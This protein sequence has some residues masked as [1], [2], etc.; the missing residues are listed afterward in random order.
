[1]NR[2]GELKRVLN[3]NGEHLDVVLIELLLKYSNFSVV[4]R[5]LKDRYNIK[6]RPSSLRHHAQRLGIEYRLVHRG[7]YNRHKHDMVDYVRGMR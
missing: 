4:C 1:M 3:S 7:W 5:E 6:I 2:P